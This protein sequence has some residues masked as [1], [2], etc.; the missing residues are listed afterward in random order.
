MLFFFQI[1]LILKKEKILQSGLVRITEK[2]GNIQ[3]QYILMI[4]LTLVLTKLNDNKILCLFEADG[5]NSIKT[6][7]FDLDWI[8]K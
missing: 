5:Y 4:R 8:T 7:V 1:Q 3:K 2:H 6:A